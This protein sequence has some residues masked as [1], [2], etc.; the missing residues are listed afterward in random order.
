M[1]KPRFR[2]W[3]REETLIVFN[4]YCRIPFKE[5]NSSHPDVRHVAKLIDRT[6][7]SVNMKIG[8]LGS[9]DPE[10]KKRGIR[11]LRNSSRLDQQVWNEFHNNWQ[12]LIDESERLIAEREPA[13]E[14]ITHESLEDFRKEG[15]D[16]IALRK[17]RGNQHFFRKTVLAA[18]E[19]RCC[20]TGIDIETLL[21][22][23]H[24]KPWADSDNAEKLNPQN[25]LCLN[26]LHDCAFDRGLIAITDDY[27]IIVSNTITHCTS[28]AV[29]KM[30]LWY[31]GQKINLPSRF[32]PRTDF[33]AWHRNN[34][35]AQC[36]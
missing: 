30:L 36:R 3:S 33:L 4:L 7:D 10:L 13:L 22:A 6:A 1:A 18:Y 19:N 24:I 23:S 31:K 20:V 34:V 14:V 28:D 16:K 17:V 11:G 27:S 26:A 29:R 35:F 8:N 12:A 21:V 32:L 2:R 25:G 15:R 5:S 9:L